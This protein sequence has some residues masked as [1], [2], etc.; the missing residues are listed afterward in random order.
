VIGNEN[1]GGKTGLKRFYKVQKCIDVVNEEM[2]SYK[3][4]LTHMLTRLSLVIP[5]SV[6]QPM[7]SQVLTGFKRFRGK[8]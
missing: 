5:I 3:A 6:L 8:K 2:S 1:N 4:F 7:K